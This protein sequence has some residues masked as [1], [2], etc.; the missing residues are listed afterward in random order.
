MRSN[1]ACKIISQDKKIKGKTEVG[2]KA[3]GI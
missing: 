1:F 3:E 2:R